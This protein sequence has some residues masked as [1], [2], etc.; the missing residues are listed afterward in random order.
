MLSQ[1]YLCNLEPVVLYGEGHYNL[2]VL[3][4]IKVTD[5]YLGFDE[6]FRKCQ[7]EESI[8]NCTTRIYIKTFLDQCGCLP[9]SIRMLQKVTLSTFITK[10]AFEVIGS[11]V[12]KI[13]TTCLHPKTERKNK[14]DW[15][16][17]PM[18][19]THAD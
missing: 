2:N 12:L 5:S 15:L 14:Y 18:F 8:H 17:A 19:W 10:T 6:K 11:S 1:Q 16:P 9:K 3:K 7:N 13:S 4:E